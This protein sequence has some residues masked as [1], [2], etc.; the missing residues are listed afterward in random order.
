MSLSD[1]RTDANS[2][3]KLVYRLAIGFAI[4]EMWL[5]VD[6]VDSFFLRGFGMEQSLPRA[7]TDIC[8]K[9]WCSLRPAPSIAATKTRANFVAFFLFSARVFKSSYTG[10]SNYS[11]SISVLQ[12]PKEKWLIFLSSKWPPLRSTNL[13]RLK[14]SSSRSSPR[15][16]NVS[17][18]L[19]NCA[20]SRTNWLT[21]ADPGNK[22]KA[23]EMD[24]DEGT[25]STQKRNAVLPKFKPVDVE[26]LAVSAFV[27]MYLFFNLYWYQ[28]FFFAEC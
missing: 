5:C 22:R 11:C 28:F 21:I 19:L 18:K 15:R 16:R 12:N 14:M 23:D 20:A 8:R 9:W 13:R 1:L 27:N 26:S 3:S 7:N 6:N 2:S 10:F 4:L 17:A 24:V 25:H